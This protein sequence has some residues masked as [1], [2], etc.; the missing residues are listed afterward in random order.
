MTASRREYQNESQERPELRI[1]WFS[2]EE[3][4]AARSGRNIKAIEIQ[5]VRFS[6]EFAQRDFTEEFFL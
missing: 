5:L 4:E 6:I 1:S 3:K 2:H